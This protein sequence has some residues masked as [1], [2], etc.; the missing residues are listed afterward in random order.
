MTELLDV[1]QLSQFV[2]F[3]V[4]TTGLDPAHDRIIEF[5]AMRF[6]DGV[7]EETL[8]FLCNPGQAITPEIE[9]LTGISNAMIAGQEPFEKSLAKVLEFIGDNPL[10]AHNISFDISFLKA[11]LHR[12][13]RKTSLSNLLYDTLLLAQTFYFYLSDHKLTTVARYCGVAVENAHRAGA[14]TLFTG[15]IF[16]A[17]IERAALYDLETLQ[18]IN[19][20][21]KDTD[22][23]NKWLF[24]NLARR[25][26]QTKSLAK[27]KLPQIDWI[28]PDNIAGNQEPAYADEASLKQSSRE[29]AR[30]FF[31][32]G[33]A[34]SEQLLN[35]EERPQQIKMAEIVFDALSNNESAM[36]E[37]G[38]GVGKSLAYLI[39][40]IVQLYRARET[41]G[42]IAVASNT[43]TLQEQIFYKEIPFIRDKLDIPFK[44]V[45]LKGRGNYI[46][47]TKWYRLLADLPNKLHIG[48][49]SAILPIV[50][51]L[52]HTKTG[53]IAENGG[54]KLSRMAYIWNEIC[55]EPGYCTTPACHK[56]GG[57]YL[58]KLKDAAYSAN[59]LVV[60]HSLLLAD[61]ASDNKVLPEY[62]ALI[63]DEA[64]NL[65][66]NA[67]SYFASK[68]NLYR[69]RYLLNGISSST[70]TE[71]G[72][73]ADVMNVSKQF[74]NSDLIHHI[75]TVKKD[76]DDSRQQATDY[77]RRIAT[78]KTLEG[79]ENARKFGVK[80]RYTSYSAAFPN[81]NL[82]TDELI[83]GLADLNR[84]LKGMLNKLEELVSDNPQIINELRLDLKNALT[85]LADIQTSLEIITSADDEDLIYW[86]E[87]GSDGKETSVELACTPLNI[88]TSLHE[89]IYAGT[90]STILT[91]ATLRIADS[92]DYMRQRTGIGFLPEET[93]HFDSIGSPFHYAEQMRF[94]TFHAR[95]G[96]ENNSDT[97]VSLLIRL[98]EEVHKGILVLFTSYSGLMNAY[99]KVAPVF[100]RLN[101]NLYAQKSGSSR[102]SILEKFRAEKESV[103]FGTMSFW[104]GVDIIGPALEILVI[105]KMPF[106]VPSEPIIEANAEKLKKEGREPFFE[107]YL[108]EAVLKFRQGVG[109]LIRSSTDVGV[110][111]NL[112]QRIDLKRYGRI[113]KESLPVESESIV[114][115]DRLLQEL[116]KFFR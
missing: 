105:D 40:A 95:Q 10:V 21:L 2:V 101:I 4:E 60:N 50:V 110:V 77:F 28:P 86:Y 25:H 12:K 83:N 79:G 88:S 22:D 108:P 38:T 8:S 91:S 13:R 52:K 93:L 81:F 17:L 89:K 70:R 42:R 29:L 62:D 74:K 31:G 116:K 92:F 111:I 82:A 45:L 3:D 113:F 85:D 107:Y 39:P 57:C 15:K 67:Y 84:S 23:P 59:L 68:I 30:H 58:G 33:G 115:E 11:A 1:L 87:I 34:I 80:K 66:K 20:I 41:V 7:A 72:L 109:R 37:A 24:H 104:E 75:E 56:Y 27:Q 47:L 16:L 100:N 106:S 102:T 54:F 76:V 61:A 43:K 49:R 9:E 97:I 18:T 53:D 65:E 6:K 98:A 73:L 96:Q 114:G 55:S 103:L 26:I 64:H 69:L 63:V 51:W 32:N 99:R 5:A 48:N 36:I 35:Y 14:D 71:H 90:G 19:M 112:D 46:C 78:E 44:A 94:F